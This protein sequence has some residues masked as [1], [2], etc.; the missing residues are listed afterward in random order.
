M[1]IC[2]CNVL[3]DHDVRKVVERAAHGETVSPARVHGCL[4]CSK[5]CGRCLRTIKSIID[6]ATSACAEGGCAV[7]PHATM[8]IDI[9]E[10]TDKEIETVA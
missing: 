3:S 10:T 2:S 6:A 1:I 7:C 9:D 8:L 5:K 4:G